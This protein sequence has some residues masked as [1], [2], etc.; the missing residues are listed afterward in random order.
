MEQIGWEVAGIINEKIRELAAKKEV[1]TK[2]GE[3]MVI[4]PLADNQALGMK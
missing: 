3:F 4:Q 1:D 2:E